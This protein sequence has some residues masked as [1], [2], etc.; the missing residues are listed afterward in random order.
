[1]EVVPGP[2][3]PVAHFPVEEGTGQ[4]FRGQEPGIAVEGAPGRAAGSGHFPAVPAH[5][6]GTEQIFE[7]PVGKKNFVAIHVR[8]IDRRI[9]AI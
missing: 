4:H 7:G 9:Q 5:R 2:R 3:F 8:H 1:M 6:V